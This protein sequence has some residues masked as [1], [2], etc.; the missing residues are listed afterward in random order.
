M[1]FVLYFVTILL[2]FA[3]RRRRRRHLRSP[4]RH[5]QTNSPYFINEKKIDCDAAAVVVVFGLA[6]AL[7]D[8]RCAPYANLML[9][10]EQDL[11]VQPVFVLPCARAHLSEIN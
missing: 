3:P 6:A 4:V 11:A 9:V 7:T 5:T 10:V 8:W 2:H 1:S